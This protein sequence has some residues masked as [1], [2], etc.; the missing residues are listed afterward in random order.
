MRRLLL[1]ANP[2]ASGFTAMLHRSVVASLRPRFQVTPIW[3]DGPEEAEAAASAAA[4]E[5]I[6]VV[7]AMGGDGIVHRVAN[8]LVGTA[9]A[10]AVIPAGTSNVFA[11]LTGHP[12]RGGAAAVALAASR[13]VRL[14]PTARLVA[15]GETG[16]IERVAVF[17][18]GIGYDADVIHDSEERP[19]RKV[20][21]GTIHYARSA[22][23]VALA[24]YRRRAPDLAV[25]VDG[26]SGQAVTVIAQVHDH[27]TYLGRR[28]LS[29]SPGGGPAVVTIRRATPLRLMRVV[30]AAARSRDPG[31]VSGVRVWHPFERVIATADTTVGF[32][33]D[34]E[35]LG[36]ISSLTLTMEPDSLRLL[37]P[38]GDGW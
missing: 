13:R 18:A 7:A 5:G 16:R 26:V 9:T 3:P 2:A 20:G 19:L 8:G 34:G 28:A 23:R 29:I 14:L 21:A 12:R 4:A 31:T 25:S 1:V 6:D 30:S 27:F 35:Y 22:V 32:E 37:D 10:L 24:G 15:G 38:R 17:A 36:R 33:A 11:R